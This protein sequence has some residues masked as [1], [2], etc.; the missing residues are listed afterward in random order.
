V[1]AAGCIG[2]AGGPQARTIKYLCGVVAGCWIVSLDWVAASVAAGM[3]VPEA[4]Y[5]LTDPFAAGTA[6]T[7]HAPLRARLAAVRPTLPSNPPPRRRFGLPTVQAGLTLSQWKGES[8]LHGGRLPTR[9]PTPLSL[10]QHRLF[11][12]WELWHRCTAR[13][14]GAP[15]SAVRATTE[16]LR[17]Y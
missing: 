6:V 4:A 12:S 16:L 8:R 9:L 7:P 14:A 1:A 2:T 13:W 15:S 11:S 17:N 5:E 10:W 3:C